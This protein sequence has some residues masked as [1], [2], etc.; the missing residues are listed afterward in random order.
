VYNAPLISAAIPF[1][2]RLP[3]VFTATDD[4][5]GARFTMD[6]L[7]STAAAQAP[8][9]PGA[10]SGLPSIVLL[11]VMI[12]VFYFVLI[13][14]QSK[15][16]KEHR[17]MISALEAGAEVVTN[18]GILGKVVEL[19]E[20]FLTIEIADGVKVKVQR[21]TIAQVLPKGTLKSA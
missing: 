4:F 19:G 11:G 12:A 10:S 1:K 9:A 16:A 5:S 15:R 20:S 17:T 2:A 3:P 8:S 6:W 21:H 13:R 18:G 7:I 14:P